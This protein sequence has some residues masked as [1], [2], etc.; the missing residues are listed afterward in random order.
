MF[1]GSNST[2]YSVCRTCFM[3]IIIIIQPSIL[4]IDRFILK[5]PY[6]RVSEFKQVDHVFLPVTV[7]RA[8]IYISCMCMCTCVHIAL[9][10]HNIHG[11]LCSMLYI[12]VN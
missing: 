10:T 6:A 3:C 9:Y 5:S 2:E 4:S 8:V 11:Q 1:S 7:T 12:S